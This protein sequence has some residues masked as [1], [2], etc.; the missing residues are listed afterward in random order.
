MTFDFEHELVRRLVADDAAPAQIA[1]AA[2]AAW[3][4]LARAREANGLDPT[5][6][7]DGARLAGFL[8]RNVERRPELQE[9]QLALLAESLL[10][11]PL[12]VEG[13]WQYA[14]EAQRA[15][16]PE[17]VPAAAGAAL[18]LEPDYAYAWFVLARL[19]EADGRREA[20]LAAYVRAEEAILNCHLKVDVAHPLSRACYLENLERTDLAVVRERIHSLRLA[21]YF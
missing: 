18:R 9:R 14:L 21:L 6:P 13:H 17:L 20:A 1:R 10:L 15:G 19:H 2:D 11:D 4:A 16:R 12:D 3:A 5:L 7:A 8:Y